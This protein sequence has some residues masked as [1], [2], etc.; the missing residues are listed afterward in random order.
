MTDQPTAR[1][2]FAGVDT[3]TDTHHAAVIDH[4]GRP[5]ADAQ[6]PATGEG[7]RSLLLWLLAFGRV[8]AIGVEGTGS[9]GSGL[10]R[11]LTAAG[12]PVREVNRPDPAARHQHGKSDPLDAYAA[13]RAVA[14]QR[15]TAIPKTHTGA[16]EAIRH[17]RTARA[18]AIKARTQVMNQLKSLR[19]TAPEPVRAPLN[20][21][22]GPALITACTR[23]RPTS[24][25]ADPAQATRYAMRSLARRYR[26]LSEEIDD[27]DAHLAEL[28]AQT[29]PDLLAV[30]G[31]GPETAGQL[32]VTI[33]DNPERMRSEAAFAH[34]TGTAPIPASSGRTDRH[35]L[36]RGGDR[37][38]NKALHQI[39]IVRM[40]CDPRTRAYVQRRTAEGL[41]KKDII[42]CLK[43]YLTRELYHTLTT[44]HTTQNNLTQ[45]A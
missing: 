23:L 9:Y 16:V 1:E 34:L 12:L 26:T 4:L 27:L 22:S 20:A 39:V 5:V 38:A 14:S 21:L 19:V 35:R 28:T 11:V 10:A 33:G 45:T 42:R 41:Q 3:H 43:R 44:R 37:Q 7:Y 18:S 40:S 6:F 15:A 31:V 29:A 2:V 17:L 30:F 24:H 13:A 8:L 25:L 36:N 32:L